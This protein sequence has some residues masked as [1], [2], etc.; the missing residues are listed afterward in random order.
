MYRKI[1]V[2]LDGSPFAEC[3]L[4]HVKAIAKGCQVPE[5]V[6][7]TVVDHIQD[8][9]GMEQSFKDKTRTAVQKAAAAYLT[10]ISADLK[11]EGFNVVTVVQDGSAAENILDYA[12]K[13]GVDLMIMST[14]GRSGMGRRIMGG[15]ADKIVR[16]ATVPVL[17]VSSESCR[18]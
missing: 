15:T 9:P 1:L 17:A 13:Q 18:I 7:M 14:H 10:G 2:P 16:S 5:I 11:K 8:Y 6:L 4:A 3:S 12:A